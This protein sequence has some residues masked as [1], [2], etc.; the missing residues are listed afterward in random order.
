MLVLRFC[1]VGADAAL[2]PRESLKLRR[3]YHSVEAPTFVPE[4]LDSTSKNLKVQKQ[5][6]WQKF[7][8]TFALCVS[9]ITQ[10]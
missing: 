1:L 5:T 6:S 10:G 7:P 4:A 3:G 8:Q 2:V 9:G